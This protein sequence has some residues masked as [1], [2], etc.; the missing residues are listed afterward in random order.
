MSRDDPLPIAL[1]AVE[2]RLASLAP[3][4]ARL[5]RD[6]LMYAAGQAACGVPIQVAGDRAA[7][8]LRGWK[9]AT[10]SLAAS[11]IILACI[12]ASAYVTRPTG[13]RLV[14]RISDRVRSPAATNLQSDQGSVADPEVPHDILAARTWPAAAIPVRVDDANSYLHQRNLALLRGIDALPLARPG[15]VAP[16]PMPTVRELLDELLSGDDGNR[17]I[18]NAKS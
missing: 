10:F 12:A 17:Q 16:T 2:A 3:A 13:E 1:Q 9:I 4:P 11:V 18:P 8:Q 7:T 6:R 5:D 14:V 15:V